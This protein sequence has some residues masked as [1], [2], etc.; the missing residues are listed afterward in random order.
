MTDSY[1]NRKKA[2]K[3]LPKRRGNPSKEDH[4]DWKVFEQLCYIQCTKEE[5]SSFFKICHMSLDK[6]VEKEYCEPFSD[7]YRKFSKGGLCS[8]RRIQWKL[9]ET[10]VGMAIWLGKQFLDQKDQIPLTSTA[11]NVSIVDYSKVVNTTVKEKAKIDYESAEVEI[12]SEHNP[13]LQLH[14]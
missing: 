6:Y 8:L 2:T 10:N 7:V 14:P 13:T 3:K 1:A 5:I 11:L 4:V 9:A 12:I